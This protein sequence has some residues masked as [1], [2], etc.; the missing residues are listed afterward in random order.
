MNENT[1][2]KGVWSYTMNTQCLNPLIYAISDTEELEEGGLPF[3]RAA[4]ERRSQELDTS[5][6]HVESLSVL[7]PH[8]HGCV[9]DLLCFK[10]MLLH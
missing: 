10:T 3:S 7:L 4:N 8:E 2:R 5:S 6:L 9:P 1:R